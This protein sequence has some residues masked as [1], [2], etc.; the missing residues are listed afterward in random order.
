[1]DMQDQRTSQTVLVFILRH[2]N[3]N[4]YKFENDVNRTLFAATMGNGWKENLNIEML[5][6]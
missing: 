2:K 6:L 1:M 5:C 4:L 3:K